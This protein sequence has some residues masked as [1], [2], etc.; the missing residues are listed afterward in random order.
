MDAIGNDII[1][2]KT[3]DAN[4]TRKPRF[5]KKILAEAEQQLYRDSFSHLP[6]EHFVWMLWSIKESAY[7]CLQRQQ[8]DLIFSPVN[9]VVSILEEPIKTSAAISGHLVSSGFT[10]DACFRAV[11]SSQYQTLYSRSVIYGD[12][13]MHTV[14]SFDPVFDNINWGVKRIHG[15]DSETQSSGVRKFLLETSP[16]LISGK[17]YNVAKSTFGYPFIAVDGADVGVKLSLSH[18]GEWVGYAMI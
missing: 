3:I 2:L 12:E 4:R 11:I 15:T 16:L 17:A 7:K 9:T 14:A 13:V 8:P 1:A 6:L 5:Y 18:H 10:D